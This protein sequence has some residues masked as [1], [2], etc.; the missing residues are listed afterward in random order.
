MYFREISSRLFLS[1]T[2]K[3][4]GGGLSSGWWSV[5]KDPVPLVY[6]SSGLVLLEY[7]TKTCR[8]DHSH[9]QGTEFSSGL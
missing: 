2:T 3:K 9:T 4:D 6:H 1:K 7:A 8:E 5:S